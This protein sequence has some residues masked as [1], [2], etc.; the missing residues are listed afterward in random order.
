MR[1]GSVAGLGDGLSS[2]HDALDESPAYIRQ[3]LRYTSVIPALGRWGQEEQKSRLS[4]ATL[5]RSR[6]A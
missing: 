4:L 6:L 2:M 3:V 5:Q 1:A